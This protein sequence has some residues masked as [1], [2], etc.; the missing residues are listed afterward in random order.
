VKVEV[1]TVPVMGSIYNL[2]SKA[3]VGLAESGEL[4][5]DAGYLGVNDSVRGA[6]S[7]IQ[8]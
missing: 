7:T 2:A 5:V 8:S 1:K 6:H 4:G 3:G